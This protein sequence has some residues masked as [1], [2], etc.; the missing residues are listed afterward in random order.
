MEM[1]LAILYFHAVVTHDSCFPGLPA[2]YVVAS[3]LEEH[4]EHTYD[5]CRVLSLIFAD[6]ATPY[7]D[8]WVPRAGGFRSS[9]NLLTVKCRPTA[10]PSVSRGVHRLSPFVHR[11]KT[12]AARLES[13]PA[14]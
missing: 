10:R 2:S 6:G 13:G 8:R 3:G 14:F 12:S 4:T 5:A 11:G 7:D 9:L 1:V